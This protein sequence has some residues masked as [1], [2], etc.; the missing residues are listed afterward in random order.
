ME[1]EITVKV[2]GQVVG[3]HV[4]L[5]KGTLEEMEETIDAMSREVARSTLQ[6]GVDA[7]APPRPL[8]QKRAASYGTK[9]TKRGH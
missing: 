8:F 3:Q 5:L 2:N 6:A 1:V 9:D 4:E 7:V